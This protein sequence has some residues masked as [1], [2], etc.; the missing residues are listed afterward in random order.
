MKIFF[1]IMDSETDKN[2]YFIGYT[3]N[4]PDWAKD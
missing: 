4:K 1:K 3:R 2:L